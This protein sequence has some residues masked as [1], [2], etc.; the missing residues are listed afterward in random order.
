MSEELDDME[1]ALMESEMEEETPARSLAALGAGLG[2]SDEEGELGAL[3]EIGTSCLEG[4]GGPLPGTGLEEREAPNA[5]GSGALVETISFL[6]AS[7]DKNVQCHLEKEQ[8]ALS[9]LPTLKVL[10]KRVPSEE[11]VNMPVEGQGPTD[12]LVEQVVQCPVLQAE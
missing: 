9:K 11:H 8:A 7:K 2:L 12:S 5:E 3:S 6:K 4:N 10:T 1:H